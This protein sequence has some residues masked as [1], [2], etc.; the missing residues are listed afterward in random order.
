MITTG[1]WILASIFCGVAAIIPQNNSSNLSINYYVISI[2]I[3]VCSLFSHNLEVKKA[4]K[5]PD[6]Q[7]E[8]IPHASFCSTFDSG[9]LNDGINIHITAIILYLKITNI[10]NEAAQIGNIHVAYESENGDW[11][12]ITEEILLLE[13]FKIP[14]GDKFKVFPFLKQGNTLTSTETDTFL[15]PGKP[16]NGIVYFEQ[17]PS[18]HYPKMDSDNFVHMKIIVHDTKGLNWETRQKVYKVTIESAREWCP[19]FGMTRLLHEYEKRKV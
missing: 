12:L 15:T 7:I 13:Q 3:L 19:S 14:F 4:T 16:C 17:K 9:I 6:L 1:L 2:F 11:C 8:L 10:G 5:K 18:N